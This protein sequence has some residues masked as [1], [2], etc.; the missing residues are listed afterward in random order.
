MSPSSSQHARRSRRTIGTDHASI[1]RIAKSATGLDGASGESRSF[2]GSLCVG[3]VGVGLVA[4]GVFCLATFTPAT[5]RSS[6]RR[7]QTLVWFRDAATSAPAG[8]CGTQ[9]RSDCGRIRTLRLRVWPRAPPSSS[10]RS[11][12]SKRNID[13]LGLGRMHQGDFSTSPWPTTRPSR[14]SHCRFPSAVTR[15]TSRSPSVG[16]ADSN[17]RSPPMS[18]PT[19][20]IRTQLVGPSNHVEP[21]MRIVASCVV[22]TL[23]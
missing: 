16:D 15:P 9:T 19:F 7:S 20:P 5:P 1:V 17:T 11:L 18:V 21:S 12:R 13:L 10:H 22:P 3:V 4:Y 6:L 8:T 14:R 23:L 2:A